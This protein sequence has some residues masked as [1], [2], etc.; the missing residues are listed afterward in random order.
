[1][2]EYYGLNVISHE[3]AHTFGARYKK[4]EKESK[5]RSL[6][7][8]LIADSISFKLG[9]EESPPEGYYKMFLYLAE[10]FNWD[11]NKLFDN[12][13]YFSAVDEFLKKNSPNPK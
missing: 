8:E 9:F 12:A 7:F 5:E 10:M 3:F 1:M 6:L 4:Y 11:S 13:I 2:K